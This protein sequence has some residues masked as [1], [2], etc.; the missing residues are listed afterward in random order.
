M[1]K[2]RYLRIAFSVTCLVLA[3]LLCV[4]WARSVWWMD[5]LSGPSLS[6]L[7][8]SGLGSVHGLFAFNGNTPTGSPSSW[9]LESVYVDDGA[10]WGANGKKSYVRYSARIFGQFSIS[11]G[12][13]RL[14]YWFVVSIAA[15]LIAAPWLPHRFS[16]R[17]LLVITTLVAV[18]LGFVAWAIR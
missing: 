3:I 7:R 5:N 2:L 8:I 10:V 16:L 4:L 18:L 1:N 14:P 13:V 12:F 15:A 9:K 6:P 11:D 17:A